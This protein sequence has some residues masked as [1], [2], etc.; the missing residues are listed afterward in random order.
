MH[1]NMVLSSYLLTRVSFS[2]YCPFC[3]FSLSYDEDEALAR[4]IA[5]SLQ[6]SEQSSPGSRSGQKVSGPGRGGEVY[7]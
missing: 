7:K 6:D 5:Q 1:S 3:L 4:A 2:C